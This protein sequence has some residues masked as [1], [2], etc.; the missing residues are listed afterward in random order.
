MIIIRT[1]VALLLLTLPAQAQSV[2]DCIRAVQALAPGV[3]VTIQG[4][5]THVVLDTGQPPSLAAIQAYLV[6]HPAPVPQII[7]AMNAKVA[8][9]RAGLL[10]AVQTWINGQSAE[11]QLIWNTATDFRRD[12]PLI[13]AGAAALG[14]T[15]DQLDALFITAATIQP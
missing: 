3:G 9:S 13:A 2:P 15:S 12:S 10:A 14:L 6:A 8:L 7:G 11:R 1:I 4:D 5:C